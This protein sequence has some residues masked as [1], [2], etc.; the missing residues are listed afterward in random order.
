MSR[1]NGGSL[2]LTGIIWGKLC[3][4][5]QSHSSTNGPWSHIIL[6]FD[7]HVLKISS[8]RFGRANCC[9]SYTSVYRFNERL[10]HGEAADFDS[11]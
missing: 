2:L 3:V 9:I 11:V 7:K 5:I 10:L 6:N 8:P 4:F 1:I